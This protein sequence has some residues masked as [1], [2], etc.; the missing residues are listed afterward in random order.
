MNRRERRA[1]V[2]S[3]KTKREAASLDVSS[4]RAMAMRAYKDGH[5]EQA[6]IIS[7]KALANKPPHRDSLMLLGAIYQASGRHRLAVKQFLAAMTLNNLDPICYYNLACS[8]QILGEFGAAR[9]HFSKAICLGL[10]VEEFIAHNPTVLNYVD[11]LSV[12]FTPSVRKTVIG[13]DEI[14]SLANDLFLQCALRLTLVRSVR[15]ELFLTELRRAL[16]SLVIQI[17]V[18]VTENVARLLCALAQQC[19]INEYVFSQKTEE[20]QLAEQLR[21]LLL[22]RLA[23]NDEISVPILSIVAAYFPLRQ[24]PY[25][26]RLNSPQWPEWAGDLIKQ[27]VSEPLEEKRDREHIPALT[28]YRQ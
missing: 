10:V 12:P 25:I 23:A 26:E 14:A 21:N 3:G 15:L 1:A 13:A 16:L 19:F 7:K 27:Q 18:A 2:A 5:L 28:G 6:E 22:Q 24:L 4:L 20:S 17:P 11:H 8:N 9:D